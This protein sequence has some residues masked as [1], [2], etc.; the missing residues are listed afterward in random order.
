MPVEVYLRVLATVAQKKLLLPSEEAPG[1]NQAIHRGLMK[2]RSRMH[3][4]EG[5]QL[6]AMVQQ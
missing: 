4:G 6:L 5:I 3:K 1:S 2:G